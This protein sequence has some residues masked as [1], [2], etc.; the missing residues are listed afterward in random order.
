MVL[1]NIMKEK[2]EKI[3]KLIEKLTIKIKDGSIYFNCYDDLKGIFYDHKLTFGYYINILIEKNKKKYL[4][5]I[6]LRQDHGE[7]GT[8]YKDELFYSFNR[9]NKNY[10]DIKCLFNLAIQTKL[11]EIE[12]EKK[13]FY[14]TIEKM[15]EEI[16][17]KTE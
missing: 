8:D 12:E 3:I 4:L 5:K 13:G 17:S 10:K 7:F 9:F 1:H 16:G 14:R 11:F 6:Q 15:I 2:K